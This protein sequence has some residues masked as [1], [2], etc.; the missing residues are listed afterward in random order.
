[1]EKIIDIL[2]V[3]EKIDLVSN[4]K[5]LCQRGTSALVIVGTGNNKGSSKYYAIKAQ[6]V[7][8]S[9]VAGISADS[10]MGSSAPS[11]I[12]VS[13]ST[14]IWKL[15]GSSSGFTLANGSNYLIGSSNNLYCKSGTATKWKA[16][17]SSGVWTIKNG[18][19]YLALRPD[20]ALGSNGCP[21][22]RCNSSAVSTNY[23]F[24]LYK[25]S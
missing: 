25:Q 22:F 24:Y 10:F 2:S 5:L 20:L 7:N 19:R 14:I 9:Y 18:T 4:T 13:D 11:S 6:T 15:S 12:K 8:S 17:V 16:T 1:M 23:T 3:S 21:R